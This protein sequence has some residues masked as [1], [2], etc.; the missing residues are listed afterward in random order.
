MRAMMIARMPA[1]LKLFSIFARQMHAHSRDAHA[2]LSG[3]MGHFSAIIAIYCRVNIALPSL[4]P[5]SQ[6]LRLTALP[7]FIQ[8]WFTVAS[9]TAAPEG[10]GK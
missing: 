7:Y 9:V 6:L 4:S 5:H 3:R 10:P 8:D 2:A 1:T